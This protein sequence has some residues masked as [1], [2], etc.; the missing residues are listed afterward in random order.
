MTL[1]IQKVTL[2][3]TFPKVKKRLSTIKRRLN[4]QADKFYRHQFS[5][6]SYTRLAQLPL[7]YVFLEF[8]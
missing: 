1:S 7:I 8:K 4:K 2:F 3:G 6:I 5:G